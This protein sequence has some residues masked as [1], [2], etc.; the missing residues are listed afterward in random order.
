[1]MSVGR[2]AH[3]TSPARYQL[4]V[5]SSSDRPSSIRSSS[6][7]RP[8][9]SL[10]RRVQVVYN[11]FLG[12]AKIINLSIA[13]IQVRSSTPL[14]SHLALLRPTMGTRTPWAR[15]AS[16]YAWSS[17]PGQRASGSTSRVTQICSLATMLSAAGKSARTSCSVNSST[18]STCTV[19]CANR[20]GT[21]C[22]LCCSS[23]RSP[24]V[25]LF[26]LELAPLATSF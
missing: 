20:L 26:S 18:W 11:A 2:E 14:N 10:H 6:N 12:L 19:S 17:R 24:R 23:C 22:G 13:T 9:Y 16:L 5:L 8:T 15:P 4:C 7:V 3:T 25:C 21:A 1:M